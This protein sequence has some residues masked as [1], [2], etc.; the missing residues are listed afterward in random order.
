[1]TLGHKTFFFTFI[2]G[3]NNQGRGEI[4]FQ[5]KR[6]FLL[7]SIFLE[8]QAA[9]HLHLFVGTLGD[10]GMWMNSVSVPDG[11]CMSCMR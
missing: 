9:G 1:M 7:E 10:A 8:V 11:I 4:G 3:G 5:S 6:S 2:H